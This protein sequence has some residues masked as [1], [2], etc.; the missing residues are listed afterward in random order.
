MLQA[1]GYPAEIADFYSAI[2]AGYWGFFWLLRSWGS[3]T[4]SA[5]RT[6]VG[7]TPYKVFSSI[8][9]QLRITGVKILFW[10]STPYKVFSPI[11]YQLRITRVK[12][13]LFA[14]P[15]IERNS[16]AKLL[17]GFSFFYSATCKIHFFVHCWNIIWYWSRRQ[18]SAHES[19]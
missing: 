3:F 5:T 2:S 16:T 12:I 14:K 13:L 11:I 10:G 4:S 9:Y 8:I 6:D 17:V 19:C 1:T 7:S 15:Q 18:E